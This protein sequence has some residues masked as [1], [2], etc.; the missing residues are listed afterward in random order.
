MELVKVRVAANFTAEHLAR[1]LGWSP[2]KICRMESGKRGTT[3]IDV[4]MY[5]ARCKAPRKVIDRLRRLARQSEAEY[6]LQDHGEL[7]PDELIS[8]VT[9]E[10]T[11]TSMVSYEC[12]WVPG[13]MQTEGYIR[14]LFKLGR[15]DPGKRTFE[16]RVHARL[17]RQ[18]LLTRRNA[19]RTTFF[20]HEHALRA[21]VGNPKVM[22]EQ[23][24]HLA[25]VA[26]L[27]KR[28]IRVVPAAN[29]P[30]GM[31]GGGFHLKQAAKTPPVAYVELDV[32]SL[33]LDDAR[34]IQRYQQ[35]QGDL[36]AHALDRHESQEWLAGLADEYDRRAA[37]E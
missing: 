27:P 6:R 25:V 9:L 22:S 13:L 2:S 23:L 18:Q 26:G 32:A 31:F 33:F 1:L 35:L 36:D 14:E 10:T 30:F 29:A 37:E 7:L 21:E 17:T 4:A 8:L 24:T 12:L 34:Y 28:E 20:V 3:E 15:R 19:P 16:D 5:A 11:A